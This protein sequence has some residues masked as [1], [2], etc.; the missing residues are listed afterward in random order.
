MLRE[1]L[2]VSALILAVLLG[3]QGNRLLEELLAALDRLVL[4]G[5]GGLH[6]AVLGAAL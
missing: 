5:A 3:G 2:T 4:D 1:V 6:C